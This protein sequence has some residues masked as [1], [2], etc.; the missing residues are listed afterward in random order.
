MFFWTA[1]EVDNRLNQVIR[2]AFLHTH[3]Y[4]ITNNVHMRTAAMTLGVRKAAIEKHVR[5]LYP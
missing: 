5:G 4:A 3:S 1:E 2:R